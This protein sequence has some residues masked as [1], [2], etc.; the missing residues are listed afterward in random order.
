[1]CEQ[2]PEID[3]CVLATLKYW[4]HEN[5]LKHLLNHRIDGDVRY[6]LF[7]QHLPRHRCM[8]KRGGVCLNLSVFKTTK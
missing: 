2:R 1:M 6:L 3:F 8:L 7:A 5:L 4:R